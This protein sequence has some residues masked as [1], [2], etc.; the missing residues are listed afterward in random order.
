MRSKLGVFL[1]MGSLSL[2]LFSPSYA[3]DVNEYRKIAK[4]TIRQMNMGIAGDIEVVI[5]MQEKLMILGI[6]AGVE[7]LQHES[8]NARPLQLVI[9]NAENMKTL[10]LA[11]MEA[12][13]VQGKFLKGK[14]INPE[15]LDNFSVMV[16][17]MDSVI[18]PATAYI[19]L[20]EYK[21]TGHPE[22]LARVKI[23]LLE[24]LNKIGQL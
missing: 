4:D 6:E 24:A 3:L 2:S 10:S 1:L 12:L 16:I 19:A 15:D 13:W 21:N 17:L 14:G 22:L 18:H 5:A 23:E 7:F 8:D 20:E 11:R 9:V